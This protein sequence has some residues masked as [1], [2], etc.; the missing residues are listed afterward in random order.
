MKKRFLIFGSLAFLA[1][2]SLYATGIGHV[3]HGIQNMLLAQGSG[4]GVKQHRYQYQK[5]HMYQGTTGQGQDKMSGQG[6]GQDNMSEQGQGQG[7][8]SEQGQGK[9]QGNMSENGQG[10]QSK[11]NGIKGGGG[12]GKKG[13]GGGKR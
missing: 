4:N 2:S 5:K 3:D 10:G 11:G 8:I 1:S 6:Q 12:G 13:G 7:K 9:S